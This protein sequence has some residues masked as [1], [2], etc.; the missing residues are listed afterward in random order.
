MVA[1]RSGSSRSGACGRAARRS[2]DRRSAARCASSSSTVGIGLSG[3]GTS[4]RPPSSTREGSNGA[5]QPDRERGAGLDDGVVSERVA[6]RQ[7]PLERRERAEPEP[8]PVLVG[9]R[10]IA[11]VLVGRPELAR[12][13]LEEEARGAAGV[14]LDDLPHGADVVGRDQRVLPGER[15]RVARV[16]ARSSRAI[17]PS[18]SAVTRPTTS[19]VVGLRGGVEAAYEPAV[20][21][22]AGR[23]GRG[24]RARSHRP[25]AQVSV[26]GAST[27]ERLL[28]GGQDRRAELV[29]VGADQLATRHVA[30]AHRR[31]GRAV[32]V[33]AVDEQLAAARGRA[34][35]GPARAPARS[36]TVPPRSPSSAMSSATSSR[37][38]ARRP[39]P[40][41]RATVTESG[42]CTPS[43]KSCVAAPHMRA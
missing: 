21:A 38:R 29:E 26:A 35:R 31:P 28:P 22:R 7:H 43:A 39:P 17:R 36:P 37:G 10:R 9:D 16:V 1:A 4:T 13:P 23:R 33:G 27:V 12:R 14:R 2:G 34:P 11:D 15:G 24:S 42:R 19:G 32:R 25:V 30:P 6:R 8:A 5:G 20:V 40:G 41:A 18:P 3:S